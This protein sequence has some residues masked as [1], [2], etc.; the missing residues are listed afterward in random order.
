MR[1]C[2]HLKLQL[3]IALRTRS[4]L[5]LTAVS[6]IPTIENDGSPPERKTSIVTSGALVPSWA[7]LLRIARLK[8]ALRGRGLVFFEFLQALCQC[9]ELCPRPFENCFLHLKLLASHEIE[10]L[11]SISLIPRGNASLHPLA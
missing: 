8:L 9:L 6:A 4:L 10:F 11:E 3:M 7:R 2:G 5:S 1:S